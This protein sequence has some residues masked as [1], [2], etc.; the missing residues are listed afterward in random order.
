MPPSAPLRILVVD[1]NRVSFG[2]TFARAFNALGQEVH[3]LDNSAWLGGSNQ[4]LHA[5]VA[6]RLVRPLALPAYN[7]YVLA[8]VARLRPDLLFI[9]KGVGIWSGTIAAA[10]RV[11]R[12]CVL[13]QNDD[14]K[15]PASTTP[16]MRRAL[17]LWDVVFTPRHFSVDELLAAGARRVECLRYAYDPFLSYPPTAA[18]RDTTLSNSA[19]FVGTCM[20]DR[21]APLEALARRVPVAVFGQRWRVSDGSPLRSALRPAVFEDRLRAIIAG[22]GVNIE[23]VAKANRD[24]HNMRTFEIPA[25]GGFMLGQRTA[26]H[27]DIFRED[28]EAAFFGSEEELVAK[29][30]SYLSD[31]SRR[32][33]VAKA[34][35]L[36]VAG[37]ERYEDRAAR[38]LEVVREVLKARTTRS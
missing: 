5:R 14:V 13:F 29:A 17:P 34:G 33:R 32:Q 4:A 6:R 38:V 11:A 30:L 24:Q 15:N 22:A 19:V 28:E 37:R 20:P 31:P 7:A 23:L 21:V 8:Q 26:D 27:Q 36:R 18:E 25:C 3:S 1:G 12:A 10:R 9:P 35:H 2:A 16:D